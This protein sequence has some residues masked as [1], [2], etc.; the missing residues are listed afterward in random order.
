M[1]EI[2]E[3]LETELTPE[4]A[5]PIAELAA[6]SFESSGPTIDERVERMMSAAGSTD[7]EKTSCRRFVIWDGERAVAHARTFIRMVTVAGRDIPVLALATVCSH[8]DM[9]GHGLGAAITKKAFEQIGQP[10]WPE[11]SLFQTPVAP[12]YEKLNSRIVTNKFI[13]STNQKAP[14]AD[15]WRDDTQMIYPTEFDWPEGTVDLNGPDY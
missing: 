14:D 15:P 10:G 8:P 5:R 6:A 7:P 3:Y 4:I 12:F 9:R 11:V 13:D 2:K 1:N